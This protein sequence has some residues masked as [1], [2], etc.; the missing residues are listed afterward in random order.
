MKRLS[1]V[2]SLCFLATAAVAQEKTLSLRYIEACVSN[3]EHYDIARGDSNPNFHVPHDNPNAY[4]YCVWKHIRPEFSDEDI[5][6]IIA[7]DQV[8]ASKEAQKQVSTLDAQR[9][10]EWQTAIT[11]KFELMDKT[12]IP[13]CDQTTRERLPAKPQK[14]FFP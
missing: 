14:R 11:L 12:I 9:G 7:R 6:Y 8:F 4:C 2:L 13:Y 5:A 3:V 1:I 10:I